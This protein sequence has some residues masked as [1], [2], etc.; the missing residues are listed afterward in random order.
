MAA[1][2]T[3]RK[4]QI[5]VPFKPGQ[6][7]NPKGRPKGLKKQAGVIGSHFCFPF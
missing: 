3:A 5:G 2:N 7:G 1:D 6:G 4:Q